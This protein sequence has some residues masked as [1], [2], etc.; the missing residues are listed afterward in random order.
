[1][2]EIEEHFRN[3]CESFSPVVRN[4]NESPSFA[5]AAQA[6]HDL[7]MGDIAE[8]VMDEGAS[9]QPVKKLKKRPTPH[10]LAST[11]ASKAM[12]RPKSNLSNTTQ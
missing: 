4:K 6:D 1:M 8:N 10:Y 11:T 9:P 7:S 12:R 2:N 5:A 3:I